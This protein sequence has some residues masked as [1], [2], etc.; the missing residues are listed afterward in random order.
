MS[1]EKLRAS[2]GKPLGRSSR[3]LEALRL[4]RLEER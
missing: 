3:L 1:A 2:L 4:D